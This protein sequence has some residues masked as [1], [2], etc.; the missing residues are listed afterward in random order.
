MTTARCIVCA[1]A[2]RSTVYRANGCAMVASA[3]LGDG[4]NN[5]KRHR[6]GWKPKVVVKG[7]LALR[8]S[9]L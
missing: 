8:F 2:M 3:N 6:P 5:D 1:P 9:D 7:I 4:T